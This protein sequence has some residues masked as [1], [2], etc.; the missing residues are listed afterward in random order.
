MGYRRG[1]FRD[2]VGKPEGKRA[3][4]RSRRRWEDNPKVDLQEVE[5]RAWAESSCLR[6][7]TGGEHL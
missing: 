1:V 3:L 7:G 4:G 6:I 2:F 5:S